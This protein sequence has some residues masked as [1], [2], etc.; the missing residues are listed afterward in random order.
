[1]ILNKTLVD[2]SAYGAFE[3]RLGRMVLLVA[4]EERSAERGIRLLSA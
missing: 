2:A 1:M 4:V 3:V